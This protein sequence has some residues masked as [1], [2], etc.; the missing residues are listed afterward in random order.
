MEEKFFRERVNP[1]SRGQYGHKLSTL[2]V[3]CVDV[4]YTEWIHI[5]YNGYSLRTLDVCMMYVV[6]R[7][8]AYG[9]HT[10]RAG[11]TKG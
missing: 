4:L 2:R 10:M 6:C 11:K 9:M 8:D 3:R 1:S 7:R 5:V